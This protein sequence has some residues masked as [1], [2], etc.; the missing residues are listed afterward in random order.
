MI[1]ICRRILDSKFAGLKPTCLTH[2]VLSTLTAEVTVIVNN[3]PLVAVSS[4]HS[5]TEVLTPSTL[6]TQKT[7]LHKAIPAW[8]VRPSRSVHQT[9]ETGAISGQRLLVAMEK[10]IPTDLAA[11]TEVK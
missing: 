6:L 1:G 7:L 3:R 8:K 11:K 9:V 5:E 10:R 2:E 4:D